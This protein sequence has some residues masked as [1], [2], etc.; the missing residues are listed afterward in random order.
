M[1]VLL[2]AADQIVE[3]DLQD[4]GLEDES[5]TDTSKFTE[6]LGSA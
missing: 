5:L 3:L 2:T 6:L 1:A 4:A